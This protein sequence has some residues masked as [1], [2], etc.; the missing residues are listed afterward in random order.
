MGIKIIWA[1]SIPILKN[2]SDRSILSFAMPISIKALANPNPCNRPKMKA[3]DQGVLSFFL[4]LFISIAKNIKLNAIR[5]SIVPFG[6]D[7]IPNTVI[8]RVILWAI[9]NAVIA[10]NIF[11]KPDIHKIKPNIN[12][13][14]SK[15]PNKCEIPNWKYDDG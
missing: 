6:K 5:A 15:P 3:V 13:I 4:T 11:K 12:R 14:W 1:T 2:N 10:F 9:V 8:P 7:I